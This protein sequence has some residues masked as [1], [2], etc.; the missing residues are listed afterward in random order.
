MQW[1]SNLLLLREEDEFLPK[2]RSVNTLIISARLLVL[3]LV[4]LIGAL[5]IDILLFK[6]VLLILAVKP[7]LRLSLWLGCGL[8]H[9]CDPLSLH[10]DRR[11]LGCHCIGLYCVGRCCSSVHCRLSLWL[12]CGLREK[13]VLPVCGLSGRRDRP[14]AHCRTRLDCSRLGAPPHRTQTPTMK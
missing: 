3:G 1:G 7:F 4:I 10:R 6:H 2:T 13:P 9:L 11:R 14:P 5:L 8:R 12:G